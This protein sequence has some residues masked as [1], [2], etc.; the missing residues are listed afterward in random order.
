[1]D[2]RCECGDISV[3]SLKRKKAIWVGLQFGRTNGGF[4]RSCVST[5]G[6]TIWI[7]LNWRSSWQQR[8]VWCCLMSFQ[9]SFLREVA[10]RR[11]KRLNT[12]RS[13]RLGKLRCRTFRTARTLLIFTYGLAS[14]TRIT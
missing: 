4:S 9:F 3:A 7:N 5:V 2:S 14:S 10:E 12:G 8:N 13:G 1:L 11:E 6:E